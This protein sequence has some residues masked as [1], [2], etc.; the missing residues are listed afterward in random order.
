MNTS[1]NGV[2]QTCV[3]QDAF[4]TMSSA[5]R[6]TE[7]KRVTHKTFLSISHFLFKTRNSSWRKTRYANIEFMHFPQE[8][9][10]MKPC[11]I[12]VNVRKM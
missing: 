6:Q 8:H 7:N 2:T 12:H 5:S 10:V 11:L 1:L 4:S 9:R 3:K